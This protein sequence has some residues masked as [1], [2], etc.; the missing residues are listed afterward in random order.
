MR[1]RYNDRFSGKYKDFYAKYPWVIKNSVREAT[2]TDEKK[3]G[4]S[5]LNVCD[6]KCTVKGCGE[7]RT[8]NTQDVFQV[9]RCP[10][11]QAEQLRKYK[12]EYHHNRKSA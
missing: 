5:H 6:I 9:K 11:H 1:G 4:H 8:V 12:R 3:V 7:V 2:A 10:E